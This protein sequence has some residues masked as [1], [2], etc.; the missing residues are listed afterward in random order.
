MLS[1][2]SQPLKDLQ[3]SFNSLYTPSYS[4]AG[5]V[6]LAS[7]EDELSS[8]SSLAPKPGKKPESEFLQHGRDES[9]FPSPDESKAIPAAPQ[10]QKLKMNYFRRLNVVPSSDENA[11]QPIKSSGEKNV[12]TKSQDWRPKSNKFSPTRSSDPIQIPSRA[13]R[14]PSRFALFDNEVDKDGKA[15]TPVLAASLK[16]DDLDYFGVFDRDFE[17]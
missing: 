14:P 5:L 6:P 1:Y 9:S 10:Y 8:P 3:Y 2:K 17:L 15:K 13:K 12:K 11:D 16:T 4:I 7:C